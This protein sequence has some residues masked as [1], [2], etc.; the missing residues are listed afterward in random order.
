M[1]G[2]QPMEAQLRLNPVR[3]RNLL[4]CA[5]LIAALAFAIASLGP[6]VAPAQGMIR[7]RVVAN[8]NSPTDQAIKLAVRDALVADLLPGA[9]GLRTEADARA[10]IA[11]R[12]VSLQAIAADAAI[13]AGAPAAQPVTVT[14]GPDTFPVRHLGWVLFPA[15]SYTTLRIGIGAAQGHNWWT[16]LFPPLAFVQLAKGLAV[17]GPADGQATTQVTPTAQSDTAPVASFSWLGWLGLPGQAAVTFHPDNSDVLIVS[18][19]AAAAAPVQVRFFLWD[20]THDA[21]TQVAAVAGAH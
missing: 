12:M 1:S 2:V 4:G 3:A 7:L 19:Q 20:L 17:V 21:Q 5:A 9:A 13:R 15:G 18:D 14:L 16:V 10:W 11:I 6:F 8:S